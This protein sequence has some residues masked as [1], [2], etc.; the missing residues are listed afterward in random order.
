MS[1]VWTPERA[2]VAGRRSM[3]RRTDRLPGGGLAVP[4]DV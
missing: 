3:P 2:V 1:A 4:F